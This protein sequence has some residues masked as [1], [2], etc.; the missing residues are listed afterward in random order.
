MLKNIPHVKCHYL[1]GYDDANGSYP[2]RYKVPQ[3]TPFW[4]ANFSNAIS[5]TAGQY[6]VLT[7]LLSTTGLLATYPQQSLIVNSGLSSAVQYIQ[8]VKLHGVMAHLRSVG[9]MGTAI[10]SSDIYNTIRQLLCWTGKSYSQTNISPLQNGGVD[11]WP[12]LIDV[13]EV[14]VDV[15]QD[16]PSLSLNGTTANSPGIKTYRAYIPINKTLEC[17]S[18]SANGSVWDTREG[19][20]IYNVVSDSTVSPS[21]L[22]IATF[23]VFYEIVRDTGMR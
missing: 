20:L 5:S 21:P 2:L 4:D 11:T 13:K 23:R 6:S 19:D 22:A 10:N 9:S 1:P 16:L 3:S 12:N 15:H 8:K 17:Y 14:L 18:N 7:P